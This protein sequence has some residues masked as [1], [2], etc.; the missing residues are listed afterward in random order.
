MFPALIKGP[1]PYAAQSGWPAW[2]VLPAGIV[3]FILAGLLGTILAFVHTL[4]TGGFSPE[5]IDPQK[6]PAFVSQGVAAWIIGLQIGLIAFTWLAAGMFNSDR[7][8]VLSLKP[9]AQGW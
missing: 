4:V 1:S 3:I 5:A 8:S 7:A 9:P 6:S 2:A